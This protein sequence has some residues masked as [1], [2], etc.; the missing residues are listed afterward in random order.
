MSQLERADVNAWW[1]LAQTDAR[2]ARLVMDASPPA[3]HLVCFL[4]Q[5]AG[6]K[7]VK[8]LLELHHQPIPRSHDITLLV[9]LLR[10]QV[11]V[12]GVLDDAILLS[13]YGVMPRYPHPSFAA[14]Q[15][16]ATDALDAAQRLLTWAESVLVG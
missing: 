6:E 3:W 2:V 5:Q 8:A 4:A 9:E 1:Q 11:A 13:G 14:T 16:D 15:E 12:D 7:A 10:G